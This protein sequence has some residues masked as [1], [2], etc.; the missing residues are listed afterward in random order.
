MLSRPPGSVLPIPTHQQQ[1]QQQQPPP[2]R[3]RQSSFKQDEQASTSSVE[4]E[5]QQPSSSKSKSRS[6]IPSKRAAQNRAAQKAFRQRREQYIKDLEI[7]A[8]EMEDWQAEMDK[9]RK[10]NK[11]LRER[12]IVLENQVSVLTGGDPTKMAELE[13]LES[14]PPHSIIESNQT[15]EQQT[16]LVEPISM[17]KRTSERS[18]SL[19]ITKKADTTEPI[20]KRTSLHESRLEGEG[21]VIK[22]NS[23]G[24]GPFAPVPL[25][26]PH[27]TGF[28]TPPP[29][30]NEE[31]AK[32]RKIDEQPIIG[33]APIQ[34]QQQFNK[35]NMIQQPHI[36]YPNLWENNNNNSNTIVPNPQ[37]TMP[38]FELDFD[39]DPFFEDEFGPTLA[40]NNDFLPNANSNQVLDDL[41]AMLQTRQ[42]PQI[43]MIP[44]EDNNDT[45]GRTGQ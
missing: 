2:P 33:Q 44:S 41:F 32:R 11:E 18:M 30:L 6:V 1:Q 20:P 7:K 34:Q 16:S 13:K 19:P 9:L 14:R 26:A 21:E 29:F 43:P 23:G 15:I 22:E 45:I 24:D 28:E 5:Q 40:N 38:E 17:L 39:F 37:Q 25:R 36:Q 12:V 27:Q 31:A 35:V 10:E 42:R 8:K 4:Y 3:Q